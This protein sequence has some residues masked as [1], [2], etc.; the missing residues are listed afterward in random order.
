[1]KKNQPF[2]N[3][4]QKKQNKYNIEKNIKMVYNVQKRKDENRNGK[5]KRI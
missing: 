4:T 5:N 3:W 2:Q 1:M